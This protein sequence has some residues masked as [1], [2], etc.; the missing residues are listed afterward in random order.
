MQLIIQVLTKVG[1]LILEK[2]VATSVTFIV[3][4]FALVHTSVLV[5]QHSEALA[6]ALD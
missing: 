4:P 6:L 5:D 1:R 2:F 3:L